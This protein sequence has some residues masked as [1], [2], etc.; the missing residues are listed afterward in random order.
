VRIAVACAELRDVRPVELLRALPGQRGFWARGERWV[1]HA[2]V[3]AALGAEPGPGRFREIRDQARHAAQLGPIWPEGADPRVAGR[4]RFYGGFSFQDEPGASRLWVGF[5][6]ALFH[7]P[8]VELEG[9]AEGVARLRVRAALRD[10]DDPATVRAQLE[11]RLRELAE[12]LAN[13]TEAATGGLVDPFASPA[14]GTRDTVAALDGVPSDRAAWDA[15]V[16]RILSAIGAGRVRKVVLA[17]TLDVR[18]RPALDPLDVLERLWSANRTAHVFYFE[19]RPER[20]LLGA[21]PETIATLR[22]GV[23]HATAVAGSTGRGATPQEQGDLAAGLMASD[24][25][26][27]EHRISLDDMVSRLGR[28]ADDVRAELV[29]HVLALPAIQHLET[30]IRARVGEGTT[31]LDLVEALHPT[32]AVCGEPREQ[33][34]ETLAFEE[35]FERGWYS[36]PVGWFDVDG[37]GMFAPALRSAVLHDEAWRLYAGAGIVAGSRPEAEW[38]ETGIKLEPVL[39]ALTAAAGSAIAPNGAADVK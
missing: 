2:G 26:R 27:A 32:P 28:L 24:K 36:G 38:T 30:A 34:L 13:P 39:R 8:A 9:D 19:P 14:A 3:L 35:P 25:D 15:S 4:L 17:R 29:P 16:D 22:R 12:R 20:V 18:P 7:L 10:G 6:A 1:A 37:N 5:P 21:A 33:A 31:V 23:F 11:G